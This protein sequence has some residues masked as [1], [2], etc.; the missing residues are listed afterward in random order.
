MSWFWA[1]N[2]M[3]CPRVI[4]Y[5]AMMCSSCTKGLRTDTTLLTIRPHRLIL[6]A[7]RAER[8]KLRLKRRSVPLV[9]LLTAAWKAV[10]P[11]L[12]QVLLNLAGFYRQWLI[13]FEVGER[14]CMTIALSVY[15]KAIG[16]LWIGSH[17]CYINSDW[18]KLHSHQTTGTALLP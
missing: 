16:G 15:F 11:T 13:N 2:V 17:L 1:G 4:P 3:G 14:I 10:P 8:W 6:T 9:E 18:I 5:S 12:I 7:W